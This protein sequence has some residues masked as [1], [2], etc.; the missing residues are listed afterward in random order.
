MQSDV[1]VATIIV[2]VVT[3]AATTDLARQTDSPPLRASETGGLLRA[4]V[5]A[6]PDKQGVVRRHF[7]TAL[8]TGREL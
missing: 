7:K 8:H 2:H 1:F 4:L 6:A 5:D 3:A